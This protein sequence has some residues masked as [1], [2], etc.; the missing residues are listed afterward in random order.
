MMI[1]LVLFSIQLQVLSD[2]V[3]PTYLDVGV[4]S[5]IQLQFEADSQIELPDFLVV[6][7]HTHTHTHTQA[8]T[9]LV[10]VCMSI[11]LTVVHV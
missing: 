1:S 4:Q 2:W 9:I 3:N 5:Q 8:H 11:A 7:Q 6:S 10:H